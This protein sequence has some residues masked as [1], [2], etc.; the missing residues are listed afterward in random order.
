M[1]ELVLLV[2]GIFTPYYFYVVYLFLTDKL[3]WANLLPVISFRLN[4]LSN[5]IW[6]AAAVALTGIPFIM[7]GYYV[8]THLRK[9]LIQARKNWSILLL[10]LVLSVII[11]F[12]N[13]EMSWHNWV[14]A[15]APF[16]AFHAPAYLYPKKR[17]L[18]ALLFFLTVGFILFVQYGTPVWKQ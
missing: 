7:G 6:I 8:Q 1:N 2:V 14:L 9:M 15:A 3:V 18:P 12:V 4:E 11:P 10:Y 17:I 13:T 16:A 5:S